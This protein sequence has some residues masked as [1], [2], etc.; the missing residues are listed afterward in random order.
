MLGESSLWCHVCL[1]ILRCGWDCLVG[2]AYWC[3]TIY[4]SSSWRLC[5]QSI[6]AKIQY[7]PQHVTLQSATPKFN[8]DCGT[9]AFGKAVYTRLF[10]YPWHLSL[11][12]KCAACLCSS[13]ASL[14]KGAVGPS[15]SGSAHRLVRPMHTMSALS[16][17]WRVKDRTTG[18]DQK[19]EGD[20]TIRVISITWSLTWTKPC[21]LIFC[22]HLC[23][24]SLAY[25]SD[26][27]VSISSFPLMNISHTVQATL[28]YHVLYKQH[29]C[30]FKIRHYQSEQ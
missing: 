1:H 7:M 25:G 15:V 27:F 8:S 9:S 20:Q 11:D 16:V 5:C 26:L 24:W 17:D 23:L 10:A 21:L 30:I 2:S 19:Q 22:R 12:I 4:D 6:H 29:W 14:L 3:L 28:I 13:L 18:H